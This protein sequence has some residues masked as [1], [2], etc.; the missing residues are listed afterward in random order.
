MTL[1]PPRRDRS[2]LQSRGRHEACLA[3]DFAVPAMTPRKE[4]DKVK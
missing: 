1:V 2:A 4:R 3:R